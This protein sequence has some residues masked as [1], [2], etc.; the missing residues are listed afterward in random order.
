MLE[1]VERALANPYM[2]GI[3]EDRVFRKEPFVM[4]RAADAQKLIDLVATSIEAERAPA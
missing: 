2:E 4:I 1:R 3:W